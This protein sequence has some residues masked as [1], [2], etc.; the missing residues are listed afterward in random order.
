MFLGG[1]LLTFAEIIEYL[2]LK[3]T[4]PCR[5]ERKRE[6]KLRPSSTVRPV[7]AININGANNNAVYNMGN[8]GYDQLGYGGH[9]IQK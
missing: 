6:S 1:S 4:G 8:S 3:C 2:L 7:S 9:G 5:S